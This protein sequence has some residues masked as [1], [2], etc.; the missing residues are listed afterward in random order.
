[1][2]TTTTCLPCEYEHTLWTRQAGTWR[3]LPKPPGGASTEVLIGTAPD[4]VWVLGRCAGGDFSQFHW[5]GTRWTDRIVPNFEVLARAVSRTDVWAV[6]N[7]R[8]RDD[9][10]PGAVAHWNGSA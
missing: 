10:V 3:S 6:G 5:N 1:V 9:G 2:Q 8:E 7:Y 4:D